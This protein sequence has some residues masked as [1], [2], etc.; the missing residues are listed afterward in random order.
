MTYQ[1]L[2]GKK[3]MPRKG[4][5]PVTNIKLFMPYDTSPKMETKLTNLLYLVMRVNGV[6]V[7]PDL[8][9]WR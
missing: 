6:S 3:K 1:K 9:S 2:M 8:L 4:I 5:C 7:R